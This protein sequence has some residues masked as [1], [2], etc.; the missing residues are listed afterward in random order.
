MD[1]KLA[2]PV[3]YLAVEGETDEYIVHRTLE[4]AGFRFDRL[5]SRISV[6]NR[7]SVDGDVRLLARALAVPHADSDGHRGARVLSPLTA[8]IVVSDPEKQFETQARRQDRKRVMI[9]SVRDTL[10]WD[11]RRAAV[12]RDLQHL[13]HIR[14]WPEEFEFAHLSDTEL[15]RALK[16][17]AGKAAPPE[18]QLRLSLKRTHQAGGADQK[19]VEELATRAQQGTYR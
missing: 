6:V 9:T 12:E 3:L 2:Q 1:F 8:L 14:A 18:K 17:V 5:S 4:L 16:R 10:P 15:A 7:R 11:L 13:V 19:G